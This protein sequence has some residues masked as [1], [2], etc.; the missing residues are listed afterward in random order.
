MGTRRTPALRGYSLLE[1]L[2]ALLVLG[3]LAA[4]ALPSYTQHVARAQRAQARTQLALAAQYLERFGSA[5]D[6]YDE[7]RTGR[8]VTAAL[9]ATL[10]QSPASGTA[11]YRL[12]IPTATLGPRQFV[13]HMV[14]DP[15]GPMARDA[16]GTLTLSSTGARGV[17][18]QGAPGAPGLREEC[19]R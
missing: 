19:W 9:P 5:N 15:A 17:L 2:I 12:R 4:I 6:R 1:G 3:L 11:V 10:Q 16:C 8:P 14:P 13:L 18:V 7:D